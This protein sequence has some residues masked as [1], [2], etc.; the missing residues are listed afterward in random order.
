MDILF[1]QI[2]IA[3]ALV[4]AVSFIGILALTKRRAVL[5]RALLP[6]VSF[7]A[8]ALLATALLDLL[9]EAL[10]GAE[11]SGLA[12]S[13]LFP[14]VLAGIVLFF[15]LERLLHWHH[16]HSLEHAAERM[17]EHASGRGLKALPWL[18][19]VGDFV[20]NALDGVAI[21][22]AFLVDPALGIATTIAVIAHEIPQE[23]GDFSL[24]LYSGWSV[25][26]ALSFNFLSALG[27]VVGAVIAYLTAGAVEA[28]TPLLA[29]FAAGALLYIATADL[30]P[31]LHKEQRLGRSLIQLALFLLGIALLALVG[32]A[33]AH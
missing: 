32:A 11:A 14:F 21:A 12:A 19:V 28:S 4:S 2:L 18:N 20:H 23:V 22:A 6:L 31:E 25:R 29:A 27:A 3:V 33:F 13:A 1:L 10:E 9:P 15:A 16:H 30:V 17:E 8:G 5:E 24:L 7:A 26:K